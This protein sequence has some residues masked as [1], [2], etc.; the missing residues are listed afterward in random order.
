MAQEA[1]GIVTAVAWVTAVAQ[2]W[3]LAWEL[4]YASGA[5]KKKK[6]PKNPYISPVQKSDRIAFE[7]VFVGRLHFM[8]SSP[9]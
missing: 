5:A 9:G 8:N 4:L 7:T 2:V 3:S 1:S 6:Q